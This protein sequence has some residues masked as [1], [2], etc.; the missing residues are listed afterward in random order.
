MNDWNQDGKIDWQSGNQS[1][2]G[3]STFWAVIC[4]IGMIYLFSSIMGLTEP[5]CV[6]SGC[7][8]RPKD[9]SSYC[10]LHESSSYHS[11]K[12]DTIGKNNISKSSSYESSK[13]TGSIPGSTKNSVGTTTRKSKNNTSSSSTK[14]SL[15]PYNAKDY[16]DAEDY[17]DEWVD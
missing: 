8:N 7:D 9:G 2:G 11:Y 14:K 15:D 13:S 4:I 17:Y 5:K 1:N 10:W 6:H 12:R 3:M 16:S